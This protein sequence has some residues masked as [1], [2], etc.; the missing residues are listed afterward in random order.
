MV[1]ISR[2]DA[3]RR[4]AEEEVA[5]HR[6]AGRLEGGENDLPRGPGISR[7]FEH[8]QLA[9]AEPRPDGIHRAHDVGEVRTLRLAER[10]RNADQNRVHPGEE[11]EVLGGP[12]HAV[13]YGARKRLVR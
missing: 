3:L 2:I 4:E 1:A 7:A 11:I 12:E 13:R 8:D 5:P 9:G 10:R 6:E